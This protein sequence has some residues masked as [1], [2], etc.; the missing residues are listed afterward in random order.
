MLRNRSI[1]RG[2]VAVALLASVPAALAAGAAPASASIAPGPAPSPIPG[3]CTPTDVKS[4]EL[5]KTTSGPAILVSGIKFQPDARVRL[6]PQDIVFVQQP[7]YFPYDVNSCGTGP[8]VKTP[9]TELFRVPTAP[10]GKFG[11]QID[12]FLI[13]L[14][15]HI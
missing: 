13:D 10:V 4:A 14:F 2:L 6:D 15:P 9:Y 7:E 3:I 1:R 11:I 8:V 5:V 12:E